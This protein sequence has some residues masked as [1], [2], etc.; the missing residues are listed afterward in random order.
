MEGF[1]D[2]MDNYFVYIWLTVITVIISIFIVKGK[3]A[4]QIFS[5]IDKTKLIYAEKFASGYSTKS[6]RTKY[7]GASKTLHIMISDK[8]L[9]IKTYLFGAHIAKMHDMLHRIPFE[10]LISTE[11]KKGRLFSKLFV[12][13]KNEKG[14]QKEI[15][16]MSNNNKEIK[17]ILDNCMKQQ[18]N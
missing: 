11:L 14:N 12:R 17:E 1:A 6:L 2:F 9:I 16:L 15:V 7:G 10:N 8:E 4:I 3:K 5:D 18:S 13:F